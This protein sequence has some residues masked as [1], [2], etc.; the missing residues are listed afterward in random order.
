LSN[1]VFGTDKGERGGFV[2]LVGLA[3]GDLRPLAFMMS[4][5]SYSGYRFPPVIIRQAIWL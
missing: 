5:I 4:K 2:T 1:L 3:G